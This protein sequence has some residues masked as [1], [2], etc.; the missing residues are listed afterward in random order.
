MLLGGGQSTVVE[1]RRALPDGRLD[2]LLRFTRRASVVGDLRRHRLFEAIIDDWSIEED[3]LVVGIAWRG[4]VRRQR[5]H[6][7]HQEGADG[8]FSQSMGGI[9]QLHARICLC[10]VCVRCL[11]VTGFTS[12]AG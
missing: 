6:Q 1:C 4:F 8:Q 9:V 10:L 11:R 5:R 7:H 12:L 3:L 2:P